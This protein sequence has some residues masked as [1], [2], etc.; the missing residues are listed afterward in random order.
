VLRGISGPKGDQQAGK[1]LH[2]PIEAFH[3][4]LLRRAN[5]MEETNSYKILAGKPTGK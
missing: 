5:Q 4:L 2:R 3:N 1:E